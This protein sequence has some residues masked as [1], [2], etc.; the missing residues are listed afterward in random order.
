MAHITISTIILPIAAGAIGAFVG[1]LLNKN[2]VHMWVS[3]GVAITIALLVMA[4][5]LV[6]L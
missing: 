2:G 6:S 5:A 3:I 4:V 1:W